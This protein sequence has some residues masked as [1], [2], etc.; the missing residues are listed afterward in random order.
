MCY[1]EE[2]KVVSGTKDNKDWTVGG[3]TTTSEHSQGA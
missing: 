2:S 1:D 3:T